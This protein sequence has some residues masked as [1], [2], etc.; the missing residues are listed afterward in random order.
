MLLVKLQMGKAIISLTDEKTTTIEKM[1]RVED[2][3]R[4]LAEAEQRLAVERDAMEDF[5]P[6]VAD[7]GKQL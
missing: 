3:K 4:L 5:H 7:K 2:L 1:R 6:K